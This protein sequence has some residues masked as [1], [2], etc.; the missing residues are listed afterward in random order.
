MPGHSID[1]PKARAALLK[2]L[3]A[4]NT[5][6]AS[7]EAA[8]ISEATLWR[9]L[10]ADEGFAN[11]VK[12]AEAAWQVEAVKDIRKAASDG[13]WQAAAWILERHPLTKQ[14]WKRID[15]HDMSCIPTGRLLEMLSV[16]EAGAETAGDRAAAAEAE[17]DAV[18]G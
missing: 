16:A 7:A 6:K 14:A 3:R 11:E 13:T 10:Q 1:Q 17:P 18:S 8:G 5:R 2:H 15:Q 12:E 9:W 4:A